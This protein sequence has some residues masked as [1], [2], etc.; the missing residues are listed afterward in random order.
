MT[1]SKQWK[2]IDHSNLQLLWPSQ[3]TMYSGYL[4]II[5][6]TLLASIHGEAVAGSYDFVSFTNLHGFDI[7][8][9]LI[10]CR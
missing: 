10:E 6:A 4:T 1:L 7:V 2:E 5:A 9:L 3:V 8:P